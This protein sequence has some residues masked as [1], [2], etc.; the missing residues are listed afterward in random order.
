MTLFLFV[1]ILWWVNFTIRITRHARDDQFWHM[2]WSFLWMSAYLLGWLFMFSHVEIVS[3]VDLLVGIDFSLGHFIHLTLVYV[4]IASSLF[5]ITDRRTLTFKLSIGLLTLTYLIGYSLLFITTDYL[6][7]GWRIAIINY[8]LMLIGHVCANIDYRRRHRFL[9][10]SLEIAHGIWYVLF[11]T[12]LGM[13]YFVLAVNSLLGLSGMNQPVLAS[14]AY[15][16]IAWGFLFLIVMVQ[17]DER[18]MRTLYPVRY[19]QHRRLQQLKAYILS[20]LDP[21]RQ[22]LAIEDMCLDLDGRIQ[23]TLITILDYYLFLDKDDACRQALWVIESRKLSLDE[24]SWE[25]LFMTYKPEMPTLS[26]R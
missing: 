18:L 22:P 1:I 17:P 11:S 24:M 13:G 9:S 3:R 14:F 19:W 6:T 25:M 23:E 4:Y 21:E 5:V 12:C 2:P 15:A 16:L 7:L 20:H 8:A 10:N 26:S